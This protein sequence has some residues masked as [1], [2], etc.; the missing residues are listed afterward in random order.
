[1]MS[2]CISRRGVP[3]HATGIKRQDV[4]LSKLAIGPRG[5]D[6]H[7]RAGTLRLNSNTDMPV[8]STAP[9]FQRVNPR[10]LP[11]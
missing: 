5:N 3:N 9:Q 2:C 1:M 8:R 6:A 10:E 4:G 7:R 11:A